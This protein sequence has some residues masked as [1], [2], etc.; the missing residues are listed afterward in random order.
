[1]P[2][3]LTHPAECV[4]GERTSGAFRAS[5]KCAEGV[6]GRKGCTLKMIPALVATALSAVLITSVGVQTTSAAEVTAA[7]D[8]S[9]GAAPFTATGTTDAAGTAD[10]SFTKVPR[11]EARPREGQGRPLPRADRRLLQQPARQLELPA[12]DRAPGHPRDQQHPQGRHHPD[13]AVLLRPDPG[14]ARP[15][16]RQEARRAHP[17]APERPPGHQGD[18]DGARLPRHQRQEEGLHL[19]VPLGLPHRRPQAA[20]AHEVLHVQ[21]DRRLEVGAVLRLREHDDERRPAPVERPLPDGRRQGAV[22]AVRRPLRGHGEGLRE[23][24]AAVPAVLRDSGQRR[25]LRR[26]GR[27]R[28]PR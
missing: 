23:A 2:R 8:D 24:A 14:G 11:V 7:A 12:A 18:E 4:K 19:Q 10:D 17:D 6:S 21:Q 26:R 15:D 22:Q 13:R 1:M 5:M 28:A 3:S 27:L 9:S 16:R 25:R 20:A